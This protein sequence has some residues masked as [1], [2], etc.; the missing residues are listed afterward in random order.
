MLCMT[1]TLLSQG[2]TVA[3]DDDR[4]VNPALRKLARQAA[5]D[6]VVLLRNDGALPLKGR[7]SVFGR[8]QVD[9][10]TVGYGSGGDVNAAYTTVLLDCLEGGRRRPGERGAGRRLPPVVCGE[11]R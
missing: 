3:L 10:M 7:V 5:I 9:W 2:S 1:D 4:H 6:G 8:G 11:P